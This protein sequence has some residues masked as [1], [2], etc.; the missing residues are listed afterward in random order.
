[1]K[2]MNSRIDPSRMGARELRDEIAAERLTAAAAAHACLARIAEREPVVGAWAHLDRDKVLAA[3]RALD[4]TTRRGPLHGVPIGVK[5]LINTADLPT[6]Y[7][8]PI[9]RGHRPSADAAAVAL[10]RAAGALVLG[11]TVTTEFATYHPGQ[12]A[13]P[14]DPARTPGG[15]SSGSAAAVADRM[16]PLAF[17]TQTAG[18]VIRPAAFCGIVGFKPSFGTIPRAGAKLLADSLDTIG[19]MAR[20]VDDVALFSAVLSDRPEFD[21]PAALTAP[22]IGLCL[23]LP[24][25]ASPSDATLSLIEA[26]AQRAEARGATLRPLQLPAGLERLVEAH[27]TVMAYEAAGALAYERLVHHAALSPALAALL[28]EGAAIDA[29]RYDAAREDATR[30][31]ATVAVAVAELDA[32]LAPAALDEAPLGLD[33]TGDPVF[34]RPWTLLQLPCL[35][36][37]AGY[38]PHDMPIG[39]QLI[40]GPRCDARLLAIAR[41][42][43]AALS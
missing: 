40:A 34:C 26:A 43:E 14:H 20:S 28:D 3:A 8:S 11:K 1:M 27:K 16:V 4:L 35:T 12:T 25:A 22:I 13:N 24:G 23:T 2:T 19:V 21:R 29:A 42:V 9:Y 41:F 33:A 39:A 32:V 30:I 17:G 31:G 5:D 38:G 36:L 10:A 7:G 18:S 6:E 37:P 15:S